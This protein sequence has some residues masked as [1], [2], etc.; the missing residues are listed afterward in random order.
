MTTTLLLNLSLSFLHYLYIVVV[1]VSLLC[2]PI[3]SN[4][5]HYFAKMRYF[6]IR[7]GLILAIILWCHQGWLSAQGIN[8]GMPPIWNFSKK[9]YHAG[10][11][12]WDATQDNNGVMY[13]ANNEGLL[14]YDGSHW[15]CFAVA[16][17]T[18][19]RAVAFDGGSRIYVGAQ[20]EFGYFYQSTNGELIYHS[21]VDLLPESQ[22]GFEDVWDIVFYN[23]FVFFRTNHNVFQFNQKEIKIHEALGSLT[24]MFTTPQGFFIQQNLQELLFFEAG[25]F[26]KQIE[27]KDLTSPITGAIPWV[28]DTTLL[29]TLKNGIFY[30]ANNQIGHWNTPADVLFREKRI[31]NATG[32][33]NGQIAIGTSLDGL[34]TIDRHRR[35]SRHLT[36]KNGLQN[37]NILST[38]T[39]Q[40]GDLWLGLDNGLDCV[41]LDAPFSTIIPDGELEGTGYA[42]AVFQ[43]ELFLGVSNGVYR[44]PWLPFYDPQKA[45]FFKKIK[46]TDGQV[47]ALNALG[48]ELIMGHH[49]GTFRL[50]GGYNTQLS[51]E[52][53]AWTFVQL[54]NDY[55]L[56]GTYNGLILFR[57]S[58][59]NWVFDQ[60]IKGLEESC[61]FMV[62][63][64]D[65]A[66]WVSHPYRGLYRVEWQPAYKAASKVSFFSIQNGL[67]SPLN[68]GVFSIAGK[69]I[70]AT[71]KGIM[72]FNH[73]KSSFVLDEDFNRV[74][75]GCGTVRYLKED[76]KGNIWYVSDKEVGILLVNDL[77]VKKNI[78]K[79]VF[80]ELFQ[81]L[82]NGFEFIYPV[83]E[84]NVFFGAELG[85]I[86]FNADS[87]LHKDTI[88]HLVLSRIEATGSQDT[89]LLD[90]C[91]ATANS[92]A[93]LSNW[94]VLKAG[95]N[96]LRFSFSAT[97]Y[98]DPAF[99]EYRVK[100]AGL[101]Q[102]WSEWS[103]ENVRNFTN[104]NPG[105]YTFQVQARNK[106]GLQSREVQ[107]VFRIS[108]PWY[109][110][111]AALF[112]YSLGVIGVF[113]SFLMRQRRKFEH[114][115][116][117]LTE[118]HLQITAEQQREVEQSKAALTAIQNDKLEDEIRFKNQ[119]LAAATMHLVQK[120]EILLTVKD[121]LNQILEQST[122]PTVKKEIQQ[123]LNLLNFDAKLDED[124]E[125]F[126][127]HFDQVHVDFLKRLRE[128]YPQLSINDYK[129]CA[130]LRMNLT[131]KEI[132][133][134]LN[135]SV[136][137]VEA[138]RYRLRRKLELSNDVNL[139]DL[140]LGL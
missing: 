84:S 2:M 102:E 81:K 121:N 49:E 42:V 46:S 13:W 59:A 24:A 105:K 98:K 41:I 22:R 28:G 126:A 36:K 15:N 96:N 86:H 125:Q 122:N 54:S 26:K 5:Y 139:T 104:L 112:C 51:A 60:K 29:A 21:L 123:L 20:G 138:S 23:G 99:L 113:A 27:V 47:W 82:V 91:F 107:Y 117:R 129:L 89:I 62:K 70:F 11:Q 119:E 79:R 90:N 18:V 80:P 14:Q 133:P 85:F 83:D 38:F 52:P 120:G 134:L 130:Y 8:L 67:P 111:T 100:M 39:D 7:V 131:T 56:G 75:L 12:N 31:Y 10:T 17:K 25:G 44:A 61:R 71:E 68:N 66:V 77:G 73:Q 116:E 1:V 132:A 4:I 43:N 9:L 137:G 58:G 97:D 34:I 63:D 108:P 33:F 136:R 115:K 135:I 32:L 48:N 140:I 37:N 3:R 93:G 69:A 88:L 72:R 30:R 65:G 57:K 50:N 87:R 16:N 106:D 124:W 110:S 78:Q 92:L 35:I 45:P 55:L 101:D 128:H 19:V 76:L 6:F 40:D 53:G 74:L 118:R 64:E 103:S 109:A 127:F 114:E 94:P 95:M